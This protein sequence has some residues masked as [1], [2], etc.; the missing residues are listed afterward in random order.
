MDY[1]EQEVAQMT[2]LI[3]LVVLCAL[4]VANPTA[5]LRI[6]ERGLAAEGEGRWSEALEI[7]RSELERNPGVAELWLRIADIEARLGRTEQSIAA[8]ERATQL[9]PGVAATLERLSQAYAAAGHATPALRAIEGALALQP[10]RD[11]YLRAHA[12]L[13]TWAGDYEAA[14]RSYRTLTQQNPADPELKLALA[15]VAVWGGNTDT[16]VSTYREYLTHPQALP[17]VWLELARAESW[18]GNYPEALDTLDRYRQLAGPTPAYSRELTATLARGGRPQAAL[19][20]I[21]SLLPAS[22]GD[23]D[24]NLSRTIALAALR[25][26]GDAYSSLTAADT[27]NPGRTETRAAERVLRAQLASNVGP[28][29]TFYNDSDGLEAFRVAPR[30]D[31][32]F[33]SDTRFHGGYEFTDMSAEAGSGLE[34]V[35]GATTASVEHV[36]AGVTQRLGPVTLGGTIG[37]AEAESHRS[38]TYSALV[39]F[40]SDSVAASF[41]RS[42]GFA[43]ISPRT[44]GLGL[45]RLQHRAQVDWIP[46]LRY[47]VVLDASHE[48]LSDGNVR[49]EFFVA[50]RYELARRQRF[51]LDVGALVHQFGVRYDFDNGYYDPDRYEYYAAVLTPYWKA[52]ES[53]GVAVSAGLGGQ[54]DDS[55]TSFRLGSNLSAEATFGIYDRWVFKV[56]GSVTNNR[57]L[58]S[59]AFRGSSVGAVLLARF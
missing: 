29:T 38:T 44:V 23:Y 25:R 8:L 20:H 6:P 16:A 45:T 52:S 11:E 15:R 22:P 54:R 57:R 27:L 26:Q 13:A 47:H 32:G 58:G 17:D 50:P 36:W 53:I 59:G 39:R 21:D 7:Y 12:K 33:R 34:Q 28:F 42:S 10:D 5:Q 30:F 51:N 19:K 14:E 24:L 43:A 18:R 46:A 37:R 31:V 48:D 3:S 2:R 40:A 4:F 56:N 49:W 9:E 55:S 1:E 41:E 35:S